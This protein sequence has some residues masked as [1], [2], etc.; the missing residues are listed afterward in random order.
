MK[1]IRVST[2]ARSFLKILSGIIFLSATTSS[3]HGQ[4]TVEAAAAPNAVAP[5]P[6][7]AAASAEAVRTRLT[8][9]RA[10]AATGNFTAAVSELETARRE[11]RDDSVRD[12]ACVLLMSVHLK[13]SNYTRSRELLE[14]AFAGRAAKGG[15]TTHV[16]FALVGQMLNGVRLRL[17]RYREFGLS[18]A[19]ATLPVEAHNDLGHLRLILERLVEQAKLIRAENVTNA[20]SAALVEDAA[21]VR[22]M[23]ARN[24]EERT[25]WQNEVAEARQRLAASDTR[26]LS[27]SP[28]N[29]AP[30]AASTPSTAAEKAGDAASVNVPAKTSATTNPPAA[31]P[32]T[33]T[34]ER[35]ADT[36]AAKNTTTSSA[37]PTAPSTPPPTRPAPQPDTT[38]NSNTTNAAPVSV[39]SLHDKATQRVSPTYPPTARTARVSGMVTVYLLVDEKGAVQSVQRASGPAQLQQSA[40]DAARRW[41]FRPTLIDG[42]PVRVSGY[43]SFSFTL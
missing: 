19:D 24:D 42:Q 43:L 28:R 34:P 20:D 40:T 10:L 2:A 27:N 23:L 41:K 17:D 13:L 8:H 21:S 12:V 22:L 37:S 5:A 14:E 6:N 30:P 32:S 11:A 16:Y 31:S 15:T 4:A 1:A 29:T 18:T 33:A 3:V 9:A 25:Q 39:G 7:A 38:S 36:P 26:I 35:T